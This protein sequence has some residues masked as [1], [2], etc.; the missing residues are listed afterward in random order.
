MSEK[1]HRRD[2]CDTYCPHQDKVARYKDRVL[3][4]AGL[5]GAF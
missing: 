2:L 5:I 3:E 4:V 1:E